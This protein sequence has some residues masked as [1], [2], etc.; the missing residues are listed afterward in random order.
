MFAYCNNNPCNF[1][2]PNGHMIQCRSEYGP[3]AMTYKGGGNPYRTPHWLI[4]KERPGTI[5]VGISGTIFRGGL[6][7]TYSI[8]FTIDREWNTA[9]IGSHFVGTGVEKT[10]LDGFISVTN[11]T[12]I[13][14]QSG[15]ATHIG[16]AIGDH[17]GEYFSFLDDTGKGYHGLTYTHTFLETSEVP[18]SYHVGT[19]D[20]VVGSFSEVIHFVISWG[21]LNEK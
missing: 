3:H 16:A 17:S 4:E 1:S 5:A 12:S 13:E 14:L 11:A 15:G 6:V 21:E 19:S 18:I 8:G 20:T 7:L 9:W 10:T 2:D